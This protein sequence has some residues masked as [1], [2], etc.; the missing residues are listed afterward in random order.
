MKRQTIAIIG[1]RR[2]DSSADY[3][4]LYKTFKKIYKPGDWI[5]SGG[6]DR[7][8]DNFAEY[9]ARKYRIPIIIIYANWEEGKHAGIV[10]NS[11]VANM[12]TIGLALVAKDRTGGTEDT[13][14]KMKKRGKEVV[15]L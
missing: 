14:K 10:R 3:N 15:V 13:I 11:D 6:C 1:S 7:G 2:R 12:A 4:L 8:G 9:I 5:V